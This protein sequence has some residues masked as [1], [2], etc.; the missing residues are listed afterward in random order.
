MEEALDGDCR[1]WFPFSHVLPFLLVELMLCMVSCTGL[2]ISLLGIGGTS[3]VGH[4]GRRQGWTAQA[5][6][7][8]AI[9]EATLATQC[10]HQPITLRWQNTLI[11]T[12]NLIHILP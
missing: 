10:L 6:P 12:Q 5:K 4:I 1:I 2:A 9:L 11:G 7:Q 8:G 3:C